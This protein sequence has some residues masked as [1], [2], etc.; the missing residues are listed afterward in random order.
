ME[1]LQS[2][3]QSFVAHYECN[4]RQVYARIPSFL[5]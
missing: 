3:I 2:F 4:D 1:E 5:A